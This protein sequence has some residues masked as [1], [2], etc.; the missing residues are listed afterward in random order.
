M[1]H[2]TGPSDDISKRYGQKT[3]PKVAPGAEIST[4]SHLD[5]TP[6]PPLMSFIYIPS[7]DLTSLRGALGVASPGYGGGGLPPGW[8]RTT[9][10]GTVPRNR[11]PPYVGSGLRNPEQVRIQHVAPENPRLEVS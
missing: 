7:R 3:T 10:G 2:S 8:D 5:I 11:T 1:R 4:S 9:G 6:S